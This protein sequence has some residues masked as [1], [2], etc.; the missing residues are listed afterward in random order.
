MQSKRTDAV[1]GCL[2]SNV[3]ND[4]QDASKESDL[5]DANTDEPDEQ[6]TGLTGINPL[7]VHLATQ[8]M[9]ETGEFQ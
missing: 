9:T 7:A 1:G 2:Q 6:T 3:K 5:L 8:R 4:F